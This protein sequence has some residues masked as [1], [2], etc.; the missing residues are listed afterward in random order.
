M[1]ESLHFLAFWAAAG[2]QKEKK[3]KEKTSIG[4]KLL[5]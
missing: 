2:F 4:R 3:N 5:Q 1:C